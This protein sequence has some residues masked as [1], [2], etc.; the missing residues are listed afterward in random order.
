[1]SIIT[2]QIKELA[3]VVSVW[4]AFR[5]K[6]EKGF[7]DA[8]RDFSDRFDDRL[9]SDFEIPLQK[10]LS[11]PLDPYYWHKLRP[12]RRKKFP[13]ENTGQQVNSIFS[14]TNY[15]IT[16]KG[17]ISLVGKA[18]I[19]VPYA[20]YTNAGLR[21]PK[22]ASTPGWVGWVDDVIDGSGRNKVKSVGQVFKEMMSDRRAFKV[23]GES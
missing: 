13:H 4:K 20:T 14:G 16:K 6:Y 19:D 15:H 17:N 3:E 21:E 22:E 1:M 11:T 2:G 23:M 7:E 10:A 18:Y 8:V 5:F 9:M 12:G